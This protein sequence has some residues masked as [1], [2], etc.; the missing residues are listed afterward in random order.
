[1]G[2]DR[3][4]RFVYTVTPADSG[5][6]IIHKKNVTIGELE[7]DGLEIFEGLED[8]DYLVTAGITKIEEGQKV[9]F[10]PVGE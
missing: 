7:A 4:G 6:G 9:K 10:G 8:G 5:F 2:E 1:V 3:L